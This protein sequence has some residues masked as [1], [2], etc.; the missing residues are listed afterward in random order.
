VPDSDEMRELELEVMR[1]TSGCIQMGCSRLGA[2]LVSEIL[3]LTVG[4]SADHEARRK[5]ELACLRMATDYMQLVGAIQNPRLQ[6][7]LLELAKQLTAAAEA[8]DVPAFT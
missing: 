8:T 2:V 4:R 7:D 3:R 5:R 6:R 1:L